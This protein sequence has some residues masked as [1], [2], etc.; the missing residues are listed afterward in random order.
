VDFDPPPDPVDCDGYGCDCGSST[1][2]RSAVAA[3]LRAWS[4]EFS[5]AAQNHLPDRWNRRNSRRTP[6]R[7]SR[8]MVSD[9]GSPLMGTGGLFGLSS[10]MSGRKDI[11]SNPPP[12]GGWDRSVAGCRVRIMVCDAGRR[13]GVGDCDACPYF[14]GT[15][16]LCHFRATHAGSLEAIR[17]TRP[18]AVGLERTN[19][20]PVSVS[21]PRGEKLIASRFPC[22]RPGFRAPRP[23]FRAPGPATR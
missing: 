21:V 8:I 10:S 20:A 16:S 6:Q 14:P 9:S 3:S 11:H 17:V 5:V 2:T 19:R 12:R 4:A 23:G 1:A 15:R 18:E 22:P 7:R 13:L